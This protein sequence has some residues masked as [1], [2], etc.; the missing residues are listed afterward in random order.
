MNEL[1]AATKAEWLRRSFEFIRSLE[2]SRL[3]V[4][5]APTGGGELRPR[6]GEG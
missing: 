4:R 1:E 6:R 5:N 2:A 3:K